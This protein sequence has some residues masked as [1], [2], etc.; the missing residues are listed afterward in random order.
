VNQAAAF[1]VV[2]L[3][4][5]LVRDRGFAPGAAG[6]VL[7]VYGVG[8]LLAAPLGGALA[9]RLGR[10]TTMIAALLAGAA[11]VIGLAFAR[12]VTLLAA[13]AF[14]AALFGNAFRPAA[15]AAVADL[16]APEER[17]RAFGLVYWA[18]NLGTGVGLVAAAYVSERSVR[19]LFLADAATSVA[20]AVLVLAGVPESRPEGARQEPVLGGLARV[21]RDGT[22]VALLGPFLAAVTV[23]FQF[24]LALPLDLAARGHGPSAFAALMALSCGIVVAF[25]PLVTARFQAYDSGLLLAASALLTGAGFGL[26]A[27]GDHLAVYVAGTV[28]WSFAEVIGFPTAASLAAELAPP[29]LRGRY[30]G[31]YS[32][33]FGAALLLAPLAGGTALE[34]VGARALWAGCFAV[35]VAAAAIHLAA[36]GPRRR[37]LA[38]LAGGERVMRP[39]GSG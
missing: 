2:F 39:P 7:A 30:Q 4:L 36:A 1:V 6:R 35:G 16:V 26:N 24:Q 20:C 13:L 37:R 29:E 8:S 25:Q 10:R 34:R 28:L 9:D 23:F 5:Y 38:E 18:A 15:S 11:A 21:L 19:A 17:R 22:Y 32:M 14:A 31:A 33:T 27:F 12:T 3:G